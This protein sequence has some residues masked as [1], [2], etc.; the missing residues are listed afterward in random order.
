M[1]EKNSCDSRSCFFVFI[2]IARCFCEGQNMRAYFV[3]ICERKK[4]KKE[5]AAREV[6]IHSLF[7]LCVFQKKSIV[8]ENNYHLSVLCSWDSEEHFT[9]CILY[10]IQKQK[11][12]VHLEIADGDGW[13]SSFEYILQQFRFTWRTVSRIDNK[14]LFV[15]VFDSLVVT[16]LKVIYKMMLDD[17]KNHVPLYKIKNNTLLLDRFVWMS[18]GDDCQIFYYLTQTE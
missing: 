2:W 6:N 1:I 9:T 5:I 15:I 11:F 14:K 18:V 16:H 17:C 12:N 4:G 7:R 10:F 3:L 13:F 8:E